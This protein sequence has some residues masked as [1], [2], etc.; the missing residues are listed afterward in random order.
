MLGLFRVIP[1][2]SLHARNLPNCD[3]ATLV[4]MTIGIYAMVASIPTYSF[5]ECFQIAWVEKQSLFLG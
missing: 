3:N 1:I 5:T 4:G 2:F